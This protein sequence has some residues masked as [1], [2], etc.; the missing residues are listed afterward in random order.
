MKTKTILTAAFVGALAFT[1]TTARAADPLPSWNDDPAKKAIITFVEKV[2]KPGSPGFV[3]VPA[4]QYVGQF[5][6][7]FKEFPPSQKPGSFSMDQA[8]ET[9]QNA[10]KATGD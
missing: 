5:L 9:L 4:Q 2:T 3:P 1:I 10:P 7:A 6:A 8:L